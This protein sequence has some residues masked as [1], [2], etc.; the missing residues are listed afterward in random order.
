M[1]LIPGIHAFL[2]STPA[3]GNTRLREKDKNTYETIKK[4]RMLTW[5]YVL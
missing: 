2:A 3:L 1:K 4:I 5:L